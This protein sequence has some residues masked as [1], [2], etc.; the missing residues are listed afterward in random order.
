MTSNTDQFMAALRTDLDAAVATVAAS[1]F[2]Q[3]VRAGRRVRALYEA[4][5]QEAWHYV[6]LTSSFTPLSARRMDVA[7]RELRQWLLHH[8]ADELGH[9]DMALADLVD[10][11]HSAAAI[12]ASAPRLGTLAWVHFFYYQVTMRPPFA[13]F[14]VLQFLEG[15]ATR[16]AGELAQRIGAALPASA[17][18]AVRF[19]GEHGVLDQE[20][21][22]DQLTLLRKHCKDPAD[23]QVVR[24]TVREAGAIKRIMLDRLVADLARDGGTGVGTDSGPDGGPDFET[25]Q[26]IPGERP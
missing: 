5:L 9:E 13:A 10:L 26:A 1:P 6:R 7:H 24:Q 25:T 20:H 21:F 15:M 22:A 2:V 8:S 17:R 16:L 4:Y 11:G 23:Q 12:R 18:G 3:D 19:F 14:G